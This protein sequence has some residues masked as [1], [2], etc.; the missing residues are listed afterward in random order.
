MAVVLPN[1]LYLFFSFL[2]FFFSIFSLFFR[3]MSNYRIYG[4]LSDPVIYIPMNAIQY[5]FWVNT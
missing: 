3:N 2:K 5:L 4:V 1:G